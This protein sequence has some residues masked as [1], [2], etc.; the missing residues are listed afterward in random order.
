MTRYVA[1]CSVS[2][3]VLLTP[4]EIGYAIEQARRKYRRNSQRDRHDWAGWNRDNNGTRQ[5]WRNQCLGAVAE[6]AIGKLLD[7]YV[8]HGV[9]E[10]AGKSDLPFALEVKL[11]GRAHY[12]LRVTP[13]IPEH[14][15][16]VGVVIEE[17][18]ERETYRVPGW[19]YAWQAREVP[20]W[21][22]APHGRPPMWCVPQGAL[23]PIGLLRAMIETE[24][25]PNRPDRYQPVGEMVQV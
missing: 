10:F 22:M 1:D 23:N 20:E 15:R 8:P 9:D 21:Q 5:G 17:G 7:V 4:E 6:Q 16:V 12:G 18:K 13:G 25:D 24:R 2:E 19:Y 3:Y 14:F 11:I